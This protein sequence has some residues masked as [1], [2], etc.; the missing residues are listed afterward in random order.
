MAL[1]FWCFLLVLFGTLRSPFHASDAAFRSIG[2]QSCLRAISHLIGQPKP[3]AQ[4]LMSKIGNGR[5]DFE[6]YLRVLSKADQA[7]VWKKINKKT[8]FQLFRNL[9]LESEIS[10]ELFDQGSLKSFLFMR[11][12]FPTGGEDGAK[13][14][15]MGKFGEVEIKLTRP[16]AMQATP[17]TQLQYALVMQMNPSHFNTRGLPSVDKDYL[18]KNI[19]MIKLHKKNMHIDPNRPVEKVS[20]NDIQEFI[21]RLNKL[22]DRYTYDLPTE[23]EWEFAARGGGTK[24]TYWFG[25]NEDDL[26]HYAWVYENSNHQTQPV[27][28]WPPNPLGIYD[29]YGNVNEIVRDWYGGVRDEAPF[30]GKMIDPQGPD[31]GTEQVA[32]GG[33]YEQG[34]RDYL[35]RFRDSRGLE[36]NAFRDAGLQD[37]GFRLIRRP[38]EK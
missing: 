8:S 20:G 24:T 31:Y 16:F 3:L 10:Q 26:V 25:D 32:R 12:G 23:A 30:R 6:R 29:M 14:F 1:F 22:Q 37:A 34:K 19:E 11:K 21:R 18:N 4:F 5:G 36:D 28:Y 27:A 15:T 7:V 17:V 9:A 35:Y 33:S 2:D 13:V 38:R